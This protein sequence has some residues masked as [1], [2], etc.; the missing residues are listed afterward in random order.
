MELTQRIR[1][2]TALP[3]VSGQEDAV[4]EYL[5]RALQGREDCDCRVD[6]LGNLIVKKTGRQTPAKS[7]LITAHMDEV[8]YLITYI[9]D[10]GLLRFAPVGGVSPEVMA[11]KRV[12]VGQKL[13]PGLVGL[14]A[15][16]Q[17]KAAERTAPPE[18]DNLY[19]DIG[20]KSR[21]EAEAAVTLGDRVSFAQN[22]ARFGEG[23]VRAKA[24]D[25]RLGCAFLLEL[26]LSESEYSFTGA[27]TVQEENG[28]IGARAAAGSVRPDIGL[29]LETTTASDLPGNDGA[30]K[31]SV[32]G[33]G[34]V[35]SYMDGG[36]IYDRGLFEDL[37]R[38]AEE[39]R[40]PWQTKEYI[41]GGNDAR[42]IQR[43]KSGVR[44]AALSA[45]M[46][47]LHAPASVGS[48]FDF[49]AML[50]LTRLFLA[51]Q[52]AQLTL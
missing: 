9:E 41:A 21:E 6:A 51:D 20:A 18:A 44:V 19:I 15:V 14:K 1:E 23:F 40:I 37:R 12:Y 31:V 25:N 36:T 3:G 45:A 35:I 29:I 11:G 48:I 46:R 2:L 34:P 43:T 26:L 17:Q 13:L 32:V 22:Y 27:F 30:R 42:T 52:A 5:L 10:S 24:L 8:G 4:R 7:L 33:A 49:E 47:Y 28:C 39:H 38:L 50:K 16:H